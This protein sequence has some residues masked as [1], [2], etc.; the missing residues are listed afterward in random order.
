M[1]LDEWETDIDTLLEYYQWEIVFD[2]DEN[3]LYKINTKTGELGKFHKNGVNR[4]RLYCGEHHVLTD[5]DPKNA[6]VITGDKD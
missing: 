6:E 3:Q 2:M 4:F 5:R 1:T